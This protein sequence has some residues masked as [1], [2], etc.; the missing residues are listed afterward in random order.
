MNRKMMVSLCL[1]ATATVAL[2]L[3]QSHPQ[4]PGWTTARVDDGTQPPVPPKGPGSFSSLN[5]GTQPP[6]P[7]KGPGA[8]A[9]IAD[10]TQ[11][12]VPPKGPGATRMTLSLSQQH[13]NGV[14]LAA[15]AADGT[16]PPVPP[17]GPGLLGQHTNGQAA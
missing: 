17:K 12:P 16:Q 4:H 2:S 7:P 10:G 1:V 9:L 15:L 13:I 11:P 14:R 8:A 5:D 3:T 6:V